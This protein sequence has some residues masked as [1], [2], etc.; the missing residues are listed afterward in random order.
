MK[1]VAVGALA[2]AAVT[3]AVAVLKHSIPV[4]GLTSLYLFAILPIAIGWGFWAAGIV[5]V[6]SFLSFAF[7][8]ARPLHTFGVAEK[9]TAAS[10]AIS[11]VAAYA[12]S[13]LARRA[14]ERAE[15]A[16]EARENVH[17]LADEQSAL[18]RVA[19]LVAEGVPTPEVFEAVTREVGLQCDADLARMERFEADGTV[20][21][22]AA[23]SRAGDAQLAVGARF[24]L[25]GASIAAR[26]H[27]TGHPSRVDSFAGE[28]GPIALEAQ[29]LGIR[30]SV[31]CPIVVGG[32][33]WGVI[34]ASTRRAAPFPPYTEARIAEFTELAAMAVANAEARA[35]L[36]ASRERVITAADDAGRRLERDLHDGV[37]QRL[38]SLAL[39]LRFA[40]QGVPP[41]VPALRDSLEHA[42]EG[43]SET[44]TELQQI[45]RGIHPTILS[46]GGLGPAVRGLAR[47]SPIQVELAVDA[48]RR[49]PAQVEVAAYYVVAEA[50]ANAAKH[51]QASQ[52]SVSIGVGDGKLSVE[53]RDNGIGGADAASGSGL[54]GL[55]DRVE[56]IGGVLEV[57]TPAGEGTSLR[58]TF[59]LDGS[60]LER[61]AARI[62]KVRGAV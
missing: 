49:M 22:I 8:F 35:D 50:L 29:T 21:A 14:H 40:A 44:L 11:I 37:Q 17:R 45:S 16:E 28:S 32:Q 23:W 62:D 33:T 7:F 15:E 53:V 56:A 2:I 38:I 54:I 47:R 10:L 43:L 18:R 12:V 52:V 48:E 46:K 39:Q 30:A 42:A 1:G 60:R 26:V 58:A 20:S 61:G 34:A 5:A 25:E 57:A 36:V 9:D 51:S 59:P 27:E 24:R 41:D 55:V 6:G 31:G 19:T 3:A 13:E 4:G